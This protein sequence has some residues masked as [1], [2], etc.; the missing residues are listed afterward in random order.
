MYIGRDYD[1]THP[2]VVAQFPQ[3]G[4]NLLPDELPGW[5][6][7][8]NR[9]ITELTNLGDRMMAMVSKALGLP[10]DFMEKNVTMNESV[11]LPR[12]FHYP[13]QKKVNENDEEHWGIGDHTDYG[14]WT[15]ILTDAPGLEVMHPKT[16]KMVPVPFVKD[17]FFM[18]AGDVLDRLTRGIY[19]S[20]RHRARNIGSESRIS[21]PFFYDPA[22]TAR[23]KYFPVE[24]THDEE[25]AAA[26]KR[27]WDGTKIRCEFDGSVEYSEFLAKKVSKVFPDLV[28]KKLMENL[29]STSSP[30]TRH[31]IVIDVPERHH[32]ASLINN[33]EDDRQKVLKHNMYHKLM[34]DREDMLLKDKISIFMEHHVWA[35]Y[36]YFQL[37]KRLQRH[38]TCVDLPWRPTNDPRMRHFITEIVA[39]EECD[40]AEDGV[41]HMSHLELYIRAMEQVGADTTPI[42]SYLEALENLDDKMSFDDWLEKTLRDCKAPAMAAEHVKRTMNLARNGNIWEVAAVFTFG[43]EDI[44]PKIFIKILNNGNLDCEEYSVFQYYLQRHIDLDGKDHAPLAIA[45]VNGVCGDAPEKWKEATV[46]VK[47]ALSARAELW[48]AVESLV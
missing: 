9:Y 31:H 5:R 39:E 46:A 2:Y 30:S 12:I 25:Q 40:E 24:T 43:R 1:P 21:I 16:D 15:M 11:V 13:V 45:L 3:Y 18:N 44:I 20:P 36:D 8:I 37:L 10:E 48:S 35:V 33:I 29:E 34:E 6:D 4:V 23:M 28:P 17:S 14:L 42:R 38:F 41:T 19:K 7:V 32:Q 47:E 22:W 27:R 26:V